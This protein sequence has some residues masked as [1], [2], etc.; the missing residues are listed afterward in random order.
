[1]AGL[2]FVLSGPGFVL[3]LL[4]WFWFGYKKVAGECQ[5]WLARDFLSIFRM[6]EA[7]SRLLLL[8][9]TKGQRQCNVCPHSDMLERLRWH[10]LRFSLSSKTGLVIL[11]KI[12]GVTTQ[13][14]APPTYRPTV[15]PLRASHWEYV[16]FPLSSRSPLCLSR[17]R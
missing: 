15:L 11:V 2:G 13:V 16:N 6:G 17:G 10:E 3:L 8:A 4:L 5:G 1:M 9:R 7:E 12:V 14:V